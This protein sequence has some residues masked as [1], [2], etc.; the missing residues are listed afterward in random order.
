MVERENIVD[1]ELN[2]VIQTGAKEELADMNRQ[3]N[4]TT[5]KEIKNT[6]CK[7]VAFSAD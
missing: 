3:V 2:T 5:N 7:Q 4:I 6:T 1:F